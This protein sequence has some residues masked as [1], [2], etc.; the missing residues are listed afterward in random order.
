MAIPFDKI[1][2]QNPELNAVQA[3]VER[4]FGLVPT[5][6][7][8]ADG[9]VPV[10]TASGTKQYKCKDSDRYVVGYTSGQPLTVSLGALAPRRTVLVI[11]NGP[12]PVTVQR[13]DGK[14]FPSGSTHVL[15]QF[16]SGLFVSDGKEWHAPA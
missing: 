1:T 16:Q 13:S 3:R 15:E 6:V 7:T 8:E 4:A 9:I 10:E 2:T 12:R 14:P 5:P 11:C